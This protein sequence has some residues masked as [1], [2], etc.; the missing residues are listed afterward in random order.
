MT[1]ELSHD[2]FINNYN[3]KMLETQGLVGQLE[4]MKAQLRELSTIKETEEL[5]KLK[6]MLVTAEK[7]KERDDL[8]DKI[9]K[10]ELKL[11]LLKSEMEPFHPIALKIKQQKA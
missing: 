8:K 3:Q 10:G 11:M 6:E 4:S 9:K 7:L 1:E 2:E 5:V